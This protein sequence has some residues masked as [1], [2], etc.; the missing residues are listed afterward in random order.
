MRLLLYYSYE[1][2]A[3]NVCENENT[4]CIYSPGDDN[5][6]ILKFPYLNLCL[7]SL[8]S[9]D[10]NTIYPPVTREEI[11]SSIIISSVFKYQTLKRI[12]HGGHNLQ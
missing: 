5:K 4:S 9:N 12:S 10:N 3:F 6:I 2:N 1:C 7:I 11:F 8:I